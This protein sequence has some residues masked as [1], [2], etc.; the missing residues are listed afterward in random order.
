M[1]RSILASFL[2]PGLTLGLGLAGG[3]AEA[4]QAR[5]GT[6]RV[7]VME[8]GKP[9]PGATVSA[10]GE[11]AATDA[12]GAA[13]LTL[14]AGSVL[15]VVTRDGYEPA[16]AR[17]DVVA[18]EERR[19]RLVLTPRL[20]EQEPGTVLASTRVAR[21]VED[22]PV[23]VE[24]LGRRRIAE[25]MSMAPGNIAML[26][27][28]MRSVRVQTTSPEL[29]MAMA[30]IRGL[31]AQYTRLLSDG[32]PLDYDHPSGLALVQL[33]PAD[34]AQ[35]EVISDGASALFGANP[36]GGVV[37]LLSRRPGTQP[38]REILFSLSTPGAADGTLWISAPA[39]GSWS[40]TYL[41]GGHWQ[42]ERD[43][44]DDGWSDQP[45]YSRGTARTRVFWDNRQGRSASGTAG[46]TFEKREGGSALA[47]QEL[48]TREA[49]GALFGQMPLGKYVLAGAGTLYVQSRVR[50]FADGREHDRRESSTI[51]I[52]LRR[53]TARNTWLAGIAADWYAIRSPGPLVSS[54]VSTRP[55]MFLHDDL[56]VAPWLLVSGSA[57]LDHHNV[58]GFQLSPRGS[59]L[60]RNGPWA[61]RISGGRSYH[62]PTPLTEETEAAGLSRLTIDGP[63]DNETASS[64]TGDFSHTTSESVVSVTLFYSHL[65]NPALIDRA[66]Y[67]LRTEPDPVVTRGVELLGTVRRAPFA[68]TGTYAYLRARERGGVEVALTPRH[69]AGLLASVE[70]ERGARAGVQVYYT[71]EQRLDA[72]P[73]RS[74]SEPYT[75]VNLL[76]ELP[77][78]RLRVFLNAENL[79]DVR[80][81]DWDPIA[82]TVRDVD[83]RWTVDVWAPLKGR[84]INAGLRIT[85]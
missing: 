44:D 65:A 69:S 32:V 34:L 20:T 1:L 8:A 16:A 19:V 77:L 59:A 3:A 24:V 75:V 48:E 54:G 4:A 42:E 82:R 23:P 78:G 50:D 47:H 10:G 63:L 52:T 68:V 64:L 84:V 6:I 81:T 28:G 27:D 17:I 76:S 18:G 22:Q 71:G 26:V 39:K 36:V 13:T 38:D 62:P 70:A 73:Y 30:R 29:G 85:F 41:F 7:E 79:T 51:E 58:H 55:G 11:S 56:Q 74:V 2:G 57:R 66:T 21:R 40:S 37:N 31:R 12:T 15:V 61:A 33:P 49:D 80:Q 67:T 53:S 60:V 9:L 5:T 35:V 83:G 46:V 14:P 45:G 43:E 25:Q 72:N